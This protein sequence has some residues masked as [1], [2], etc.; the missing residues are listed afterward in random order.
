MSNESEDPRLEDLDEEIDAIRRRLPDNPGLD[1]PDP[2]VHPLF[3]ADDDEGET[4]T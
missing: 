1:I 2:D 4:R 3:P